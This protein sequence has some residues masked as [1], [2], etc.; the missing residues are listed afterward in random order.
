MRKGVVKRR[1]VRIIL[2][3][4]TEVTSKSV[5]IVRKSPETS[6]FDFNIHSSLVDKVLVSRSTSFP[7]MVIRRGRRN[8]RKQHKCETVTKISGFPGKRAFPN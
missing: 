4:T 8:V 7:F 5:M 2:F 1:F 3:C 6:L